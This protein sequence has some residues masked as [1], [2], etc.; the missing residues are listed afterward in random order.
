M[1]YVAVTPAKLK[2]ASRSFWNLLEGSEV[3][4]LNMQILLPVQITL[5]T[6]QLASQSKQDYK[7]VYFI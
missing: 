5:P 1:V 2:E 6:P 3:F 4:K 7:G